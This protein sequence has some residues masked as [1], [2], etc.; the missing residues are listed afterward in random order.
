MK[1]ARRI[2]LILSIVAA[3][4]LFTIGLNVGRDN[5]AVI[6]TMPT[7]TTSATISPTLEVTAAATAASSSDPSTV[8]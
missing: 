2:L 5:T 6:L 3:A 4:A 7:A 8:S 1:Y